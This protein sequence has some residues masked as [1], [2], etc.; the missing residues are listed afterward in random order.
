MR[1]TVKVE[2]L[3]QL[4]AALGELPKATG[5]NVLRRALIK[6]GTPI[7]DDA[8][9]R[10]PVDTGWLA[11]SHT[12]GSKLSRRQ[13]AAAR[14]DTKSFAEVHLGPAPSSR[15]IVQEFGSET[16]GPQPYMRPAWDAGKRGALDIFKAELGAE[17]DK[18]AKRLAAKAARLAAKARA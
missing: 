11:G 17:I 13:R 6:A 5:R 14:K 10:A 3:R 18:A 16:Q 7:L 15:A 9:A 8:R 2:G 12:I 1:V 4:D